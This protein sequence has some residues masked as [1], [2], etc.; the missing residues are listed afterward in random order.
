MAAD[1]LP[2]VCAQWYGHID[3]D[4]LAWKA[5]QVACYYD[6]ALLVVESNTLETH[7]EG[8][9][10]EGGDQSHYIL[11]EIRNEY[12]NLYAR[13]RSAD[14]IREGA[15]LRYGF[16]T[17]V[18][19]KPQIIS[20]LIAVVRDG[21][22]EE[23]DARCLDEMLT[24]ERRLNGSYGAVDGHH[25]DLLMTRAIGLHICYHEMPLPRRIERR[26]TLHRRSA[27]KGGMVW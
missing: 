22:Y 19:T 23:R 6:H 11:S 17:N 13:Q 14:E 9:L 21:L 5:A 16:H 18:R 3:M 8:R 25:D 2:R 15:P 27:P 1:G 24:Y 20:T 4:L 10:L 7:V 26:R 12:D